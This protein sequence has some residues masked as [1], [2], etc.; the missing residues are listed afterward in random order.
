[1]RLRTLLQKEHPSH[2]RHLDFVLPHLL[3]GGMERTRWSTAY[4]PTGQLWTKSVV[5]A[6]SLLCA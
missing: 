5:R 1:M 4:R 6:R 2:I 3:P